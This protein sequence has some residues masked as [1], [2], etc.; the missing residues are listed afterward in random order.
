MRQPDTLLFCLFA[1][2]SLSTQI[3]ALI[4]GVVSLEFF[5][6]ALLS[7]CNLESELTVPERLGLAL[8]SLALLPFWAIS[9]SYLWFSENYLNRG[10]K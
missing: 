2:R 8:L 1:A 5:A 10:G 7:M 9:I 4:V 3:L 6:L